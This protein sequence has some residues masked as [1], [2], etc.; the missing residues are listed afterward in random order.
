[1]SWNA[2]DSLDDARAATESLLLPPSWRTWLRL[3]V[4]TFFVGGVGGGGGAGQAAQGAVSS[5]SPPGTALHSL[6]LPPVPTL[7]PERVGALIV[8]IVAITVVLALGYVVTGAVMEFVLVE[9]LRTRQVDLRRPFRQFLVPGLRLF[10]FRTLVLLGLL[11]S[12]AVPVALFISP[13]PVAG[14]GWRVVLLPLL[15]AGVGVVW[16]VGALVLRLTTDFVVPTMVGEGRTLLSAW[17][18]FAPLCRAAWREVAL[19]LVVRLV[20]GAAAAVV[21]GLAVGLGALVVAIPF[22]LVG[23][24]VVATVGVQ[25][26]GLVVLGVLAA[27]FTLLV[28]VLSVVVQVPV[29]TYFRYY[30]L[31]LL[32]RLD[33]RLDF[34]GR[35]S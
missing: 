1:M 34:V 14:A 32:G 17:R 7:A 21:V 30:G 6:D 12:A 26:V 24:G 8:V 25:G 22:A 11:A 10:A 5:P 4:V 29:V 18:R 31:A 20:L 2:V 27:G 35:S 15:L 9:S 23:G 28:A 19:Y 33:E 16:L 3:V 13:A